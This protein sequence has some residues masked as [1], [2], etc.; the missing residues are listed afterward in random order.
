MEKQMNEAGREG[1]LLA[2]FTVGQT[3]IGGEELVA[4]LRKHGVPTATG[5]SVG[6]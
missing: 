4:I 2:G 5:T 1:F 6:K 3:E